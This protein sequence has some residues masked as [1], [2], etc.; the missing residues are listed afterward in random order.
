MMKVEW[1]ITGADQKS[2]FPTEVGLTAIVPRNMDEAV[3]ARC[4][5]T[6]A[7][8]DEKSGPQLIS[9]ALTVINNITFSE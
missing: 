5:V 8:D 1:N 7:T 2:L 6:F 9:S 4:Y 3:S